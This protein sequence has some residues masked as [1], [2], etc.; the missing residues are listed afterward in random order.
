V[1]QIEAFL[2]LVHKTAYHIHKVPFSIVCSTRNCTI[3]AISVAI[4]TIFILRKKNSSEQKKEVTEMDQDYNDYHSVYRGSMY[5]FCDDPGLGGVMDG[6]KMLIMQEAEN[7]TVYTDRSKVRKPRHN[8]KRDM[9]DSSTDYSDDSRTIRSHKS[10]N[11]DFVTVYTDNQSAYTDRS[12]DRRHGRHKKGDS[13]K[14]TRSAHSM[15]RSA[16]DTSTV[17]GSEFKTVVGSECSGVT[18][19][20]SVT[21]DSRTVK[22]FKTMRS[23]RSGAS[24]KSDDGDY[25]H[26]NVRQKRRQHKK[27]ESKNK[28]RSGHDMD[29]FSTVTGSD[30]M[31]IVGTEY[32]SHSSDDSRTVKSSKS[33]AEDD[34]MTVHTATTE[35]NGTLFMD[36]R[37]DNKVKKHKLYKKYKDSR[38]KAE[39]GHKHV[40]DSDTV[41]SSEFKTIV[42]LDDS[43]TVKSFETKKQDN[44]DISTIAGSD[45]RTIVSA[46][47]DFRTVVSAGSDFRSVVSAGTDMDDS[48]TVKSFKTVE[49]SKTGSDYAYSET[50]GDGGTVYMDGET[51]DGDRPQGRRRKLYKKYKD[52]RDRS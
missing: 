32:S 8:R 20:S 41:V 15:V 26:L 12:K 7:D 47:S 48:N 31:T 22:S 27:R 46:G 30:F 51:D 19:G 24:Y 25:V 9:D 43:R 42:S 28:T 36:G 35:D 3:V 16:D 1:E 18:D 6:S 37:Q 38:N 14:G 13:R 34:F 11:D 23:S 50:E 44:D 52:T 17:M 39:G 33:G 4:I 45:F 5:E 21:D 10:D 40:D 49:S 29:N 2:L